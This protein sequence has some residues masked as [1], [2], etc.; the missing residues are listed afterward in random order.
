MQVDYVI[1]M[2]ILQKGELPLPLNFP[3]ILGHEPA[4]EIVEVGESVTTRKKETVLVYRGC[5]RLVVDVNGVVNGVSEEKDYFVNNNREQEL[6][7]ME[8]MQNIC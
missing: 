2:F 4:G 5:K 7:C 3:L 8:A 6:L 1:L